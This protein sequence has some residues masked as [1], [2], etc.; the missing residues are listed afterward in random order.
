[1]PRVGVLFE[2]VAQICARLEGAGEKITVRRLQS[3]LG[4]GSSA[5][6]L[7]HYRRW[8]TE[9]R[10][11]S[12]AANAS[13]EFSPALRAAIL[14]EIERQTSAAR[15]DSDQRLSEAQQLYENASQALTAA[16]QQVEELSAQHEREK[17]EATEKTGSLEQDVAALRAQLQEVD[18]RRSEAQQALERERRETETLRA[19]LLQTKTEGATAQERL[20]LVEHE[21]QRFAAELETARKAS[22]EFERRAVSAEATLAAAQERITEFREAEAERKEELA[23]LREELRGASAKIHAEVE[24]RAA[25]EQKCSQLEASKTSACP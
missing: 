13:V 11:L 23:S 7:T 12:T 18:Q 2:D 22:S 16:E 19:Q 15:V 20:R 17:T 8:L 5:S 14:A 24:R 6:V 9:R 25:V 3:E 21:A 10:D 1:M 4:G